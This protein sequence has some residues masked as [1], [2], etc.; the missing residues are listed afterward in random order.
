VLNLFNDYGFYRYR[1]NEGKQTWKLLY[2]EDLVDLILRQG[3][4]FSGGPEVNRG[5]SGRNARSC[6]VGSVYPY[7]GRTLPA[8]LATRVAYHGG[9]YD[10]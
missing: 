7:I 6:E 10:P 5:N 2:G 8:V 9:M 3:V 4:W 1:F